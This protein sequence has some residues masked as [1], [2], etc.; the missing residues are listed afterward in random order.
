MPTGPAWP[1]G[2][3]IL[4]TGTNHGADF[5][6]REVVGS[7]DG[8]THGRADPGF[9]CCISRAPLCRWWRIRRRLLCTGFA[10][11]GGRWSRRSRARVNGGS[12]LLSRRLTRGPRPLPPGILHQKRAGIASTVASSFVG[13]PRVHEQEGLRCLVMLGGNIGGAGRHGVGRALQSESGWGLR[14]GGVNDTSIYTSAGCLS[15]A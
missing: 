15:D 11:P 3:G 2:R 14:D 8:S 7:W 13:S 5:E 10:D 12:S 4:A 6:E 1:R 9:L